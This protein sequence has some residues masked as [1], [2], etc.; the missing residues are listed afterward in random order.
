MASTSD[1]KYQ[2][3]ISGLV[4]REIGLRVIALYLQVYRKGSGLKHLL[5]A[6][7][8]VNHFLWFYSVSL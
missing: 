1:Y 3:S 4:D 8:N 7:T 6:S 2:F 5:T